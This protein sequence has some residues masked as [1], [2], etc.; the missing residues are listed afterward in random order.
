MNTI[1]VIII[2]I[3]C[4]VVAANTIWLVAGAAKDKD[5]LDTIDRNIKG[6]AINIVVILVLGIATIVIKAYQ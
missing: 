2:L 6:I 1:A 3:A 4:L 5:P